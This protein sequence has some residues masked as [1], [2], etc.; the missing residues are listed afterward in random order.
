M[1]DISNITSVLA[2]LLSMI[3]L[4]TSV[5]FS[6]KQIES[7]YITKN[8]MDWIK[9][10]RALLGVFLELYTDG[11]PKN[12]LEKIRA[13]IMLY[14]RENVKSYASVVEQ[15]D[16]CINSETYDKNNADRLVICSQRMLAEVWVRVKRESGMDKKVDDKF[17]KMFKNY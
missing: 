5:I 13:K 9:E 12:E 3:S 7:E 6:K 2:I 14:F 4:I 8:R 1:E 11:A 17:E 16:E 15:L 10:V